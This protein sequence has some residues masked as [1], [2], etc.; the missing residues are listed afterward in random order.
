MSWGYGTLEPVEMQLDI[1]GAAVETAAGGASVA[2]AVVVV[3][4]VV[5]LNSSCGQ[6]LLNFD[7]KLCSTF[8]RVISYDRELRFRL[9]VWRC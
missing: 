3:G 7:V 6:W 4:G 1:T 5:W 9:M 8:L 2:A